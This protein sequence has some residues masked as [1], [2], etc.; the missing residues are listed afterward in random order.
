MSRRTQLTALLIAVAATAAW[1]SLQSPP[2]LSPQ[3]GPPPAAA[4]PGGGVGGGGGNIAGPVGAPEYERLLEAA[5]G[6]PLAPARLRALASA[7]ME[8]F[9]AKLD[10]EAEAL[11]DDDWRISFARLRQNHP[12]DDQAT[13]ES[14]RRHLRLARDFSRTQG[15]VSL[16]DSGVTVAEIANPFFQRSFSLAMYLDRRLAVTLRQPDPE[17]AAE[18][19]SSPAQ[20]PPPPEPR[21]EENPYLQ[22]HCG[23]CIPPLV[24]HEAWPGHHVA[25]ERAA[26]LGLERRELLTANRRN[27]V[28]HEGWALYA[29]WLVLTAVPEGGG[30][31]SGPAERLGAWR[32]L[33]LRALRASLDPAL[34]D[35]TVAPETARGMYRDLAGMSERAAGSEVERHLRDPVMKASYF[36]GLLQIL[37]LRS[38]VTAGEDP[39]SLLDFHDRLLGLPRTI[40]RIAREEF[41]VELEPLGSLPPLLAEGG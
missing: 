3:P 12:A 32:M 4:T 1:T 10:A 41:G 13:L 15:L 21:L 9:E 16:P 26:A 5:A 6:A 33:Y 34:H 36:I 30:F 11:G 25:Y 2:A 31:Y 39:A 18:R 37:Q 22:N 20:D 27:V 23:V 38:L 8:L 17:E 24:V 14:Y 7:A 35:G 40:P 19:S 29:E 28:Y